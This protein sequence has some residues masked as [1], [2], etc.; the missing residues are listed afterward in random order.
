VG[1]PNLGIC[2]DSG[3]CHLN[4]LD[5]AAVIRA[6]GELLVETHFHD[7]HGRR[8]EH[9]PLGDGT[10]AWPALIR[11][12]VDVRYR[13]IITFEQRDHARN[14]ERWTAYLAQAASET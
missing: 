14:A 12:L 4:G 8:D 7:N 2:V 1:A 11:A 9:N 10:I 13:G 6:C 3:H 5:V